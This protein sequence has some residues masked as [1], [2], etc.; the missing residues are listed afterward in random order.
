M[1]DDG[2][3]PAEFIALFGIAK[4][5]LI[6]DDDGR[7]GKFAEGLAHRAKPGAGRMLDLVIKRIDLRDLTRGKPLDVGELL[8]IGGTDQ[9]R[10]FD[11]VLLGIFGSLAEFLV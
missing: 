11:L 7:L 6:A 3:L 4:T 10:L 8:A 5:D 2:L 1:L 9:R